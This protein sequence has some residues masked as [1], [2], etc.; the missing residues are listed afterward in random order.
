MKLDWNAAHDAIKKIANKL[1][2]NVIETAEGICDVANA[3]M[4]DAIRTLTVTK[5]IDPRDFSLVAFGGAGPMHSM[6]IAEHLDINRILIPTVAGTFSAWGMLQTD[7]RHDDVRTYVSFLENSDLSKMVEIYGDMKQDA[8]IV[9]KKQNIKNED[10]HFTRLV[11]LRYVGQE[12]TVT[13]PLT[14]DK[15]NSNSI[16]QLTEL[17]HTTHQKI[18]GHNNP[19]GAVEVVNLRIV[20]LGN[21]ENEKNLLSTNK[22]SES[23]KPIRKKTVVWNNKEIETSVY[24]TDNLTFGQIVNGPTIIESSTSTI[25]VPENYIVSVD[26]MGNLEV[27][28]RNENE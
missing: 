3:K 14:G 9:L 13:V 26:K 12:Y 11:D 5:G 4:A 27:I 2:L 19:E 22:S 10:I 15:I 23:P 24:S 1:N 8:E 25:V 7:I 20:G 17:F 18:Y 16:K 28:R 6:L 21:L